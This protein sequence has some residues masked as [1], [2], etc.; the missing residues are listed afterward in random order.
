LAATEQQTLQSSNKS[1]QKGAIKRQ[2]KFLKMKKT[3]ERKNQVAKLLI[4]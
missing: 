4:N 1:L 3:I 2:T